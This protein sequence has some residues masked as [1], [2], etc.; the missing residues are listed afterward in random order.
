[1][2]GFDQDEGG[3]E[4]DEGAET[5]GGFFAAQDDALEAFE[6]ADGLFDAGAAPTA[7]TVRDS[8]FACRVG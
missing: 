2:D 4:S 3:S 8:E 1:V 6:L 7:R 5:C